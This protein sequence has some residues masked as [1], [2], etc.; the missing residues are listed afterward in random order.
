MTQA[1]RLE[2]NTDA[3]Q[4]LLVAMELSR[5]T[6]KLGFTTDG[7]RVRIRDVRARD[8]EGFLA[9]VQSAKE[10][11][12][13][14]SEARV[15]SC[16][17]AGRDGFWIH[18]FLEANGIANRV[19]DPA[20]IEVDRRNRRAKTDRIDVQKLARL[21]ARDVRE[22]RVLRVVNVP[23]LQAEDERLLPRQ[24]L[25]LKR[26]RVRTGNQIRAALFQHGVALDP[27]AGSLK[28]QDFMKRL[29][30]ARQWDGS[31]LPGELVAS[32]RML[33]DQFALLSRQ[34]KDL[35]R[36]QRELL[37]DA[38]AE[39]A[40]S[41][42]TH[43]KAALLASLKGIGDVGGMTLATEF[44][45]WRQFNNRREVG[46]LAGLVGMPYQSGTTGREQGISKAGNPR[47]RH[48]MV[49]LAW[50]WLRWQPDSRTTRWFHEHV[51][52]A[53]SRGKRKAIVAVARKLLVELWRF[54]E[55]GV[56]PEGAVLKSDANRHAA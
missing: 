47:V 32:V 19:V 3:P 42:T 43:R 15:V 44:F 18:R 21:L 36:R 51:G 23:P 45:G 29:G 46:A 38:K 12:G 31:A 4:M 40:R 24:L 8:Q 7:Q 9:E 11:L 37:R 49:E 30:E 5:D 1:S 16:Y 20:S 13:L 52:K 25:S 35:E 50:L 53:G 41:S 55:H 39:E 6:W 14:A 48:L 26:T 34:V 10:C 17:E 28:E 54:A 33:W 22:G 56:I 27:H 2:S